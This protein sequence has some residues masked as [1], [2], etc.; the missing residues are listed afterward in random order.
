[1]THVSHEGRFM[2]GRIELE[3]VASSS[4]K[5]MSSVE[6][7]QQAATI[8]KVRHGT[9]QNRQ[10]RGALNKLAWK[11]PA[12]EDVAPHQP[13]HH[14]DLLADHYWCMYMSHH[15]TSSMLIADLPS[16][17]STGMTSSPCS[18]LLRS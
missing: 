16:L 8:F 3:Q 12:R 7:A 1:M 2:P 15:D 10:T 4:S 17:P 9:G 5:G 13:T 14:P 6:E 18:V 11:D